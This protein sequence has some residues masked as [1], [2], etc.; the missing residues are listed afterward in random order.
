MNKNNPIIK[1]ISSEVN[2]EIKN[3]VNRGYPWPS[4]DQIDKYKKY[5]FELYQDDLGEDVEFKDIY[6]YISNMKSFAEYKKH[7]DHVNRRSQQKKRSRR[8]LNSKRR[9]RSRGRRQTRHTRRNTRRK[10]NKRTR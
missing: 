10:R 5:A 9:K 4:D 6:P 2:N 7:V 8:K 1:E 3:H